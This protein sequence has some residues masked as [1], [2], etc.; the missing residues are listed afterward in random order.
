VIG[1]RSTHPT[2]LLVLPVAVG[3][4]ALA[5]T[6]C[7]AGAHG[8]QYKERATTQ[9]IDATLADG[10]VI[11]N[12]YVAAPAAKGDTANAVFTLGVLNGA[13]GSITSIASPV[14][15]SVAI[16]SVLPEG[17]LDTVDTASVTAD[18]SQT[19]R[20]FIVRLNGLTSDL[21][22]ASYAALTLTVNG[23]S[24]T[25]LDL[26]VLRPG[27]VQL[28][29]AGVPVTVLDHP[30][31]GTLSDTSIAAPASSAAARATT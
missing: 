7:G 9:G 17:R 10:L 2:R 24:T 22:P 21:A 25:T 18:G 31:G 23:A 11:G 3:A 28:G 6:A 16:Q 14:A 13:G 29:P 19:P 8:P 5:L 1:R 26:P 12:A 27:Q 20:I 15:T 4:A 30:D